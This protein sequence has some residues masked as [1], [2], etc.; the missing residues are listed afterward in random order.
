MRSPSAV[1]TSS[2]TITV[3]PS[4]AASRARSAPSIVSWSVIARCVRP[5]VAAAFTTDDGD[6][7]QSNDA[8]VWQCRSTKARTRPQIC[9]TSDF[10]KKSKCSSARPVP[11]ATQLSEFS[12]T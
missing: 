11:R 4:G 6:A 2:P 12:A 8:D 3:S 7:R 10:L 5:R 9:W 1:L